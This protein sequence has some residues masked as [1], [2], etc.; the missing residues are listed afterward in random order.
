MSLQLYIGHTGRVLDI[1]TSRINTIDALRTWVFQGASIQPTRQVF[2]TS[3]GKSIRPQTLLTE[4]SDLRGK[5]LV[6]AMLILG[7]E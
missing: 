1:D 2:L 3:K 4:V 7:S 5:M 6:D